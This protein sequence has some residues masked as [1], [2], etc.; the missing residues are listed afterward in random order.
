MAVPGAT[1]SLEA[2]LG[3]P[4]SPGN[5]GSARQVRSKVIRCDTSFILPT[6][7]KLYN[8]T[9]EKEHHVFVYNVSKHQQSVN[10]FLIYRPTLTL[11]YCTGPSV[12]VQCLLRACILYPD[13]IIPL[14]MCSSPV[15]ETPECQSPEVLQ[16]G[17]MSHLD[18]VLGLYQG[19]VRP[20]KDNMLLACGL[21][22]RVSV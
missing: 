6:V 8:S 20:A 13:N 17:P 15:I 5:A 14:S 12:E 4:Q 1:W 22:C 10:K 2:C 3:T 21:A 19:R 18:Q 9:V 11:S 16:A 7:R